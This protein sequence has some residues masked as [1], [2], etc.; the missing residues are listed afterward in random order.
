MN[1]IYLLQA[2]WNISQTYWALQ[3]G[4]I[5]IRSSRSYGFLVLAYLF[6]PL[7]FSGPV[8]QYT[9]TGLGKDSL[10]LSVVEHFHLVFN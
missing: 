4:G 10:M 8:L 7:S 2:L 3:I 5:L 9:Y 6:S 1:K